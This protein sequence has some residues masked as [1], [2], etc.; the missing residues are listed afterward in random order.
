MNNQTIFLFNKTNLF[1]YLSGLIQTDGSI[2]FTF[3]PD[4][5]YKFKFGIKA[6]I[7]ITQ[8]IKHKQNKHLLDL[9]KDQL[10]KNNIKSLLNYVDK[11]KTSSR[12]IIQE[13]NSVNLFLNLIDQPNHPLVGIRYRDFLIINYIQKLRTEEIL[14]TE[15]NFL[16]SIELCYNL[17]VLTSKEI[18]FQNTKR[19]KNELIKQTKISFSRHNIAEEVKSLLNTFDKETQTRTNKIS[20]QILTNTLVLNPWYFTGLFDGDGGCSIHCFVRAAGNSVEF[21]VFISLSQQNPNLIM[22]EMAEYFIKSSESLS[23]FLTFPRLLRNMNDGTPESLSFLQKSYKKNEK[24]KKEYS[25]L[26]VTNSVVLNEVLLPHFK[27]YPLNTY[28]K[29][30]FDLAIDVCNLQG[31]P[32]ERS[33][34]ETLSI[35]DKIYNQA[36]AHGAEK[37]RISKTDIL[38]KVEQVY[39]KQSINIETRDDSLLFSLPL[40]EESDDDVQDDGN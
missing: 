3:K 21:R 31:P 34:Q 33:L 25:V 6:K 11:Q 5:T 22:L 35:I 4:K 39:L 2:S 9:L 19:E 29:E 32:K 12:L 18:S 24:T 40:T 8:S 37:R 20:Q 15:K 36:T 38:A 14:Y 13:N 10:E 26:V 16:I 23:P 7:T 27:K 1:A 30:A 28:K 17:H